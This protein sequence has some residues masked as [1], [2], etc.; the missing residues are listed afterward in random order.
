M[1]VCAVCELNATTSPMSDVCE[2]CDQDFK[3][4]SLWGREDQ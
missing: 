4:V 3:D 1:S 2:N